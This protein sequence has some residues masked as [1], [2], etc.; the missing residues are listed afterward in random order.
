MAHC[1]SGQL[2]QLQGQLPESSCPSCPDV[3]GTTGT[4]ERTPQFLVDGLGKVS[5]VWSEV[6]VG[7]DAVRHAVFGSAA[8][9]RHSFASLKS[10]QGGKDLFAS[11]ANSANDFGLVATRVPFDVRQD[12]HFFLAFFFDG[13]VFWRFWG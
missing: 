1:P 13:D 6:A 5:P 7:I 8:F 4:T 11:E 12:M 9:A 10:R 3:L 2:G